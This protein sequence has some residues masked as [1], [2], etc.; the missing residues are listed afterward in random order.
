[1]RRQHVLLQM[2]SVRWLYAVCTVCCMLDVLIVMESREL[3]IGRLQSRP[4]DLEDKHDN[5]AVD[6]P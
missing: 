5:H 6:V 4:W 1:M 2:S 3:S